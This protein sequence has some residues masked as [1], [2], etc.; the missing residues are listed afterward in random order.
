MVRQHQ[1]ILLSLLKNKFI[2]VIAAIVITAV[3]ILGF[4]NRENILAGLN[5]VHAG[6]KKVDNATDY[7]VL[8][9]VEDTCRAMISS[10]TSD[11]LMY[12]Q[13]KDDTVSEHQNWAASAKIRANKTAVQ[14]NEYYLKNSN[15]WAGNIPNDIAFTLEIIK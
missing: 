12:E 14:Y 11:K 8:K 7:E 2:P 15:V 1:Q 9:D 6:M 5:G 3:I 10:Y 13:Y 4:I